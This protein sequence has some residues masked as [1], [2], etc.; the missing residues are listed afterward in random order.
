MNKEDFQNNETGK[1]S[2]Y[3]ASSTECNSLL[4]KDNISTLS[5]NMIQIQDQ[6]KDDKFNVINGDKNNCRN[7]KCISEYNKEVRFI[8]D[9]E[10]I[11]VKYDGDLSTESSESCKNR[12]IPQ[13]TSISNAN[14]SD[15]C[16]NEAN[17]TSNNSNQNKSSSSKRNDKEFIPIR[18]DE[19]YGANNSCSKCS[20]EEGLPQNNVNSNVETCCGQSHEQ[21]IPKNN[22]NTNQEL[23]SDDELDYTDED[24]EYDTES[25]FESDYEEYMSGVGMDSELYFESGGDEYISYSHNENFRPE[26]R[27][28]RNYKAPSSGYPSH[29]YLDGQNSTRESDTIVGPLRVTGIFTMIDIGFN[30][31]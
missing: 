5:A 7:K 28:F 4:W 1:N 12:H 27:R 22:L 19:D 3:A 11:D 13:S 25:C 31:R 10:S 14:N 26:N 24:L 30:T 2:M 21:V 16:D 8:D 29:E 18:S 6:P 9:K 23:C 17:F 20:L 15:N